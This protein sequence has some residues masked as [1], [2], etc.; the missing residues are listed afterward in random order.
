MSAPPAETDSKTEAD[1]EPEADPRIEKLLEALSL[2]EK[3]SMMTGSGMWHSTGVPRLKIPRLKVTDGPNGARGESHEGATSACFP[4]GTALA[5]SWN[6]ELIRAVGAEIGAEVKSKGAHIL[7]GPT[8]NIHRAPLAGRN[9]EC[10]SED[11]HLTARIAAAF[12]GGVNST[13]VGTSVKHFV[14]NDS[15]YERMSISSEVSE[16]ALREIYLPP[17]EAAIREAGSWSVMS[18]YNRVNGTH[19]SENARLLTGILRE[20]WGF[21]G[22][23]VSDWFGTKSGVPSAKAGLDLEMPGPGIHM[24][25]A[26]KDAVEAG[27][28]DEA[29][30]DTAVERLLRITLRAG[31]FDHAEEPIERSNDSAEQRALVR[32]AGAEA[33]VLLRNEGVLPLN[34]AALSR[35]AV[36]GPNADPGVIQG[37]GSAQVVPHYSVSPLAALRERV[38]SET[39]VVIERGC[40]IHKSLPVLDSLW[41]TLEDGAPGLTVAYYA[42]TDFDSKPVLERRERDGRFL[43][44][45]PFAEE[46]PIRSFAARIRTRFTPEESGRFEFSLTS[47]GLSRMRIDGVELVDNWTSQESGDFFFGM[48]SSEVRAAIELEA[49]RTVEIEVDYSRQDSPLVAGVKIGCLP[50]MPADA[51]ERAVE[52]A[53]GA[54]AAI[55]IVGLDAEWEGEGGDRESMRLPGRQDE[56]VEAVTAVNPNT[57]VVVNAG[58]PVQMDWA[59]KPAALLQSWYLGHEAGNSLCDVLF[60]DV[61]ASG[62]LPTTLPR[63]IEDNPTHTTY[64]GENGEVLYGEGIFVGYRYYDHKKIEP[65]FPF[66]HGLSYARFAYTDLETSTPQVAAG[67]DVTFSFDLRNESDRVGSE[68]VQVYVHDPES[69]QLRPPQELKA[70]AKVHLAAFETRRIEITLEAAAFASWNTALERFEVEAGAFEIRVGASSRDIRQRCE[71]EIL[72]A[73]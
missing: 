24:K 32:R 50:P 68:V 43:W 15:E 18:A 36:I 46:V 73:A 48:G 10:Y 58:S 54:D 4:C 56:L 38:G 28:L 34:A 40:N 12:I 62:R 35:I 2:E 44:L 59:E 6:V 52:A 31:A 51:F 65:R 8:V 71:I 26:L 22:F 27:E 63:R 20:E 45:V 17:F 41:T 64:P 7:L 55:V 67:K 53:R 49:G 33:I 1:Q 29:V 47:A 25:E 19:A 14:C 60:G 37:G 30:I 16:R 23:V 9:F 3:V 5:A 57:V 69:T 72:P 42:G 70:F 21:D 61:D 39:E 13:G 11:P 66:G